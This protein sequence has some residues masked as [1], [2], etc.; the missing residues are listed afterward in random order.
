[1]KLIN[2][3]TAAAQSKTFNINTFVQGDAAFTKYNFPMHTTFQVTGGTLG[4]TEYVALEYQDGT[5]WR[6]ANVEGNDGKILDSDN[7]IVTIYG[8]MIN[9][10]LNKSITSAALGLEVV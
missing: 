9:V 5:S 7:S 4:A 6:A 10:R 3:T 1:M 8:R 2:K